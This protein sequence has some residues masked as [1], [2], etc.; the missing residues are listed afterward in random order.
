M[1]SQVQIIGNNNLKEG[2]IIKIEVKAEN[3]SKDVYEIILTNKETNYLK[4]LLIL[5]PVTLIGIYLNRKVKTKDKK[6][7]D[8]K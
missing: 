1:N 5:I 6:I 3:Q 8:A 4:Y 7:K 2:S